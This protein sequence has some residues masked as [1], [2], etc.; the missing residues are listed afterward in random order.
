MQ[1]KFNWKKNNKETF[2]DSLN[3][4]LDEIAEK[5]VQKNAD[6][7][8]ENTWK[9][10]ETSAEVL[11]LSVEV[12]LLVRLIDKVGRI[13]TLS[14]PTNPNPNYESLDD[15]IQDLLGYAILLALYRKEKKEKGE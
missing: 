14:D 5:L 10:L 4:L 9:N 11:N 12:A 7:S 6:Y 13:T 3:I 15:S 2:K 1:K 8:G